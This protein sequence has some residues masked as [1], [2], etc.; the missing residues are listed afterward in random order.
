MNPISEISSELQGLSPVLASVPRV[1]IFSVPDGYF[2]Q[3]STNVLNMIKTEETHFSRKEPFTSSVPEGYFDG[4]AGSIMARIRNLE[5]ESVEN[6]TSHISAIVASISRENIYKVPQGYFEKLYDSIM[7]NVSQGES[8]KQEIFRLSS[9]IASIGNEN[10]FSVPD[11][12]FE[13]LDFLITQR[14]PV[15]AK[16]VEMP[17][18]KSIV[19]YMAA[20]VITGLLGIS[21]F[22]LFNNRPDN[23]TASPDVEVMAEA[24]KIISSNSFEAELASISG[25]DIEAYLEENGQDVNAALVASV[26]DDETALPGSEEYLINENTLDEFLNKMNLNN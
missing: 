18:R 3:L 10:V 24:N 13:S 4:L 6:E 2:N 20:A 16:V 26:T 21:M 5:A 8:A 14:L 11:A 25:K 19:R 17:R 22:S 1:N 7:S 23:N 15:P 12:Y 9:T